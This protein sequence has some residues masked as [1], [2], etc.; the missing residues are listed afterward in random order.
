[1]RSWDG[2]RASGGTWAQA[3]RFAILPQVAPGFI[4]YALLRF[5]INVRG[6][7]VIGFVGAGGI[8]QEI[9]NVIAFNYY[10]EISAIVLMVIVVVAMIDL[11]SERL[12]HR[13]TDAAGAR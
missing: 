6:A 5:E 9:Y 3:C 4:S 7:S 12:R 8:G 1:M 11:V 13:I 2:V 10:E